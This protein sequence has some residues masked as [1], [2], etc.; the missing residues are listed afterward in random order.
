M[1]DNS[2]EELPVQQ[3]SENPRRKFLLIVF[4]IL[5]GAW[6][7]GM[8]IIVAGWLIT[9]QLAQNN[10][11]APEVLSVP[12]DIQVPAGVPVLGNN[13]APVT[14]VEFADLEVR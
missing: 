6:I 13:H 7:I 12:I 1:P 10:A 5:I 9:R 2:M 3:N 11:P 4:A 8:S 14:I